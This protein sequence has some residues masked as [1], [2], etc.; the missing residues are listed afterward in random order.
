[1]SKKFVDTRQ[2][3]EGSLLYQKW[4]TED[5]CKIYLSL[6]RNW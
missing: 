3:T 1:M 2:H 6:K 4:V 5:K